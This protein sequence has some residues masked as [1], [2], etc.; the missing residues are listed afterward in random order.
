MNE[1]Y[2]I[3]II[4]TP[5]KFQALRGGWGALLDNSHSD[6]VFLT[7]EWLYAW[8][9]VYGG[10]K[11]LYTLALRNENGLLQG[12]APLYIKST[13]ILGIIYMAELKMLGCG[14]GVTSEYLDFICA[15]GE[16]RQVMQAFWDFLVYRERKWHMLAIFDLAKPS[17]NISC[18][19]DIFNNTKTTYLITEKKPFCPIVQLP[20][21]WDKY[22][23]SLP[24]NMQINIKR[25]RRKIEKHFK[26]LN[27]RKS[28]DAFI[29]DAEFE[30]FIKLH[31]LR[32][33]QKNTFSRFSD[34]KYKE[35]YKQIRAL[36]GEKKWMYLFFLNLDGNDVAAKCG[37]SYKDIYYFY[38]SGLNPKFVKYGVGQLLMGYILEYAINNGIKVCDML[39]GEELHKMRWSNDVRIKQNIVAST[40]IKG[41]ILIECLRL[42]ICLFRFTK[43]LLPA[44]IKASINKVF[45]Q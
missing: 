4:D 40:N 21:S 11:E 44:K 10:N 39:R 5:E 15:K 22:I 36:F 34:N 38:Q 23:K 7:W 27:I 18:L 42:K 6:T 28:N 35:F 17:L 33:V 1:N 26:E 20:S 24:K 8:W 30:K 12:I 31:S 16:E 41:I 45:Y 13:K 32:R 19:I 25:G 43:L 9:Q 14:G 29:S 2:N 37:F 3:E